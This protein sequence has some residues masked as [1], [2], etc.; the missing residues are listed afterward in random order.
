MLGRRL[1]VRRRRSRSA[2]GLVSLDLREALRQRVT[3]HVRDVR[4]AVAAWS[5]H[6][7]RAV[8]TQAPSSRGPILSGRRA[9]TRRDNH[10]D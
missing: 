3:H 7:R 8:N 1:A 2:I 5:P 10:L 6:R 4:C 9:A